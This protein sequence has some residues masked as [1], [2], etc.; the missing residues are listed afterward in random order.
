MPLSTPSPSSAKAS[1][2]RSARPSTSKKSTS[3][4]FSPSRI[5]SSDR[6]RARADDE[7]SGRQCYDQ[8]PG[9]HEWISEIDVHA[10]DLQNRQILV[11]RQLSEKMHPPQIEPAVE[12]GEQPRPVA[13]GA[14]GAAPIADPVAADDQHLR[15]R[16]L[17]EDLWQCAHED[18]KPAIGLEVARAVGEDLVSAG[19]AAAA[20]EPQPCRRLWLHQRRVD[21]FVDDSDAIPIAAR[22]LRTLP[23]GRAL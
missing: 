2:A 5:T 23:L 8:R 11:I 18:M 10:R 22:V 7:A 13:G 3:F 16:A 14:V 21:A 17:F 20:A 4:P 19:Q 1:A 6:R 12:L 9:E 15:P